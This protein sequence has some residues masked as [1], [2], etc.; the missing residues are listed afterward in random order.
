MHTVPTMPTTISLNSSLEYLFESLQ[1]REQRLRRALTEA[2]AGDLQRVL[3]SAWRQSSYHL[4]VLK[5][6]GHELPPQPIFDEP[7]M[8]RQNEDLIDYLLSAE[9]ELLELCDS[10]L[11][12]LPEEV[13][14]AVILQR[15]EIAAFV[16]RLGDFALLIN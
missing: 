14:P 4:E 1:L 10:S 2:P 12:A 13:R 6:L 3:L 7:L 11:V 16:A 15:E 5:K 9:R 8:L